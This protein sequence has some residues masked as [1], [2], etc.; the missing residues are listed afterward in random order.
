MNAASL[1]T[2]ALVSTGIRRDL[3]APLIYFSRFNLLHFYKN[4]VYG[5]LTADDMDVSLL[6]YTSPLDLYRQ[7]VSAK[8]DV[9]QS[10]EPFSFYTQPALW[11]T[12]FA[13]RKTRAALVVPTLE[14]RPLDIKFGT[15]RAAFLRRILEIFFARAC[16]ILPLNHGARENVLACG[17]APEKIVPTMW[18]TWGID[19]QEFFPRRRRPDNLPPT[20]LFVGRLHSEKGVFVLLDAFAAV[21]TTIPAA[22]LVVAGGGPAHS[23]IVARIAALGLSESITLL[24]T[25]KNRDL[26]DMYR[27]VDV[28]CAPSLTT[29]KWAE[30]VG[31]SALQAMA[32]AVP[33]VS[34]HSGAI[35]EYVPDGVVSILVPENDPV[36]LATALVKLLNNP[37]QAQEM[38]RAGRE[39]ACAHYDARANIERAEQLVMEHCLARRI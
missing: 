17:G 19:L 37:E 27:Q 11:A 18:G 4:T 24:G 5:D 6:K 25:V 35:P 38:G 7:L 22:H 15:L 1:P 23:E 2:L 12:L 9:I 26:P 8:P 16:L 28:F 30:Q 10:V 29:R 31:M 34:T 20:V 39:Y 33:I 21:L 14:N 3:L 32:S 13:A 36:A